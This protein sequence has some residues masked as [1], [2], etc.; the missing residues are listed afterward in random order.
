MRI[1]ICDDTV[2]E[3]NAI[4]NIIDSYK[5]DFEITYDCFTNGV[6][7]LSKVSLGEFYDLIFLDIVMPVINGIEVA[8]EIYSNNK[9]CNNHIKITKNTE[10]SI[11]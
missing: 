1:A 7:F 6:E 3:I 8:K 9:V 2:D 4:K 11:K 5:S 10:N